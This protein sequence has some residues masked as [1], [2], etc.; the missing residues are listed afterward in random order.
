MRN[1][2]LVLLAVAVLALKERQTADIRSALSPEQ[3]KQFD[4]NVQQAAKQRGAKKGRGGK[5]RRRDS[6][7]RISL[8]PNA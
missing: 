7:Q 2:R 4:G 1:T 3:Q 6:A 8:R 5:G